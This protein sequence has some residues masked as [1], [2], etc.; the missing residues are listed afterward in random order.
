M[1]E[2]IIIK[3]N[4]GFKPFLGDEFQINE[5]FL[6]YCTKEKIALPKNYMESS[7]LKNE[8]LSLV[9]DLHFTRKQIKG[10]L[11]YYKGRFKIKTLV[12]RSFS[13]HKNVSLG[14]FLR[15]ISMK[16]YQEGPRS[17]MFESYLPVL[18]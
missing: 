2:K 11:T 7:L 6:G 18:L 16:I 3:T 15:F 1:G 13:K 5:I 4:F 10:L 12:R 8:K 9:Q 14:A 17:D